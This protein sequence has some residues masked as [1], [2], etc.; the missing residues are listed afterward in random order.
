MKLA[1][2]IDPLD[3]LAKSRKRVEEQMSLQQDDNKRRKMLIMF[4]GCYEATKVK[5]TITFRVKNR[6]GNRIVNYDEV[7]DKI[8]HMKLNEHPTFIRMYRLCGDDFDVVLHLIQDKLMPRRAGGK[9][10]IPP[11]IKLAVALR[12]LAGGS[13]LD[14]SFGYKIPRKN[15]HQYV[16][17][18][19][20]AIDD[21]RHPFLNNIISP[22]HLSQEDL[23]ETEKGFAALSK[24]KLRGTVAAGDGI[25]LR[26]IRPTNVEAEGD[27]SSNFTR[28]G[29]YSYGLQAF[30]DSRCKFVMLSSILLASS[31][32]NTS[33]RLTQLSKDIRSG[34][35][36]HLYHVVLDE[37]FTCTPQEMSP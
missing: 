27:V 11:I 24:N 21:S 13:Y 37:A 12:F 5:R 3:L 19:I 32:D 4:T 10:I 25:I 16:F 23:I 22:I 14:L 2:G 31:F 1:H 7:A 15:V 9:H 34:K 30:C 17:Q 33:Y 35:L 29:T 28:K 26:I 6:R 36:H 18:V 20:K 8:K